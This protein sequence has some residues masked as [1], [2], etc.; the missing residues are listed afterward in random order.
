MKRVRGMVAA[1]LL[2]GLT[3]GTLAGQWMLPATAAAAAEERIDINSASAEELATLPGI[4]PSKAAAIVEYRTKQRFST[5]EELMQVQ[6]VGAKLFE[7]L[8]DRITVGSAQASGD[9][10]RKVR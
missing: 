9:P 7:Q 10:A 4:G 2:C 3:L 8:K 6:G 1:G 5:A